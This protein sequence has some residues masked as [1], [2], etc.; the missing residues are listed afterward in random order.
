MA[1]GGPND[2]NYFGATWVFRYD[3]H[4]AY[5]QVGQKLVGTGYQGPFT[6]LQGKSKARDA[7]FTVVS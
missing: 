4:D 6:P 5:T 1:V 7:G 2:N 3:G